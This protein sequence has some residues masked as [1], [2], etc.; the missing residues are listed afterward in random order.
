MKVL[1]YSFLVLSLSTVLLTSFAF[2]YD[3]YYVREQ[4]QKIQQKY[5]HLLGKTQQILE[6]QEATIGQ[7]QYLEG[8]THRLMAWAFQKRKLK[9]NQL[10][11]Q[12]KSDSPNLIPYHTRTKDVPG[13]QLEIAQSSLSSILQRLQKI[14]KLLATKGRAAD[15]IPIL[16]PTQGYVTSEFGYRKSP[17]TGKRK[18]HKGIDIR[19]T[20]GTKVIATAKGTVIFAGKRGGYG[21]MVVVKHPYDMQTRYA[22]LSKISVKKGQKLKVR[23][24]VG[25]VGHSGQSTG[26]HLHYET[27]Y[28]GQFIDPRLFITGDQLKFPVAKNPGVQHSPK[29]AFNPISN[30]F[31]EKSLSKLLV[32]VKTI[33]LFSFITMM[34]IFSIQILLTYI[35]ITVRR[36]ISKLFLQENPKEL[37]HPEDLHPVEFWTSHPRKN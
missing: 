35:R 7:L 16:S 33:V 21:N 9:L 28:K 8:R 4:S 19:A 1:K 14:N 26:D 13:S 3:W 34:L 18:L 29:I 27:V 36:I 5:D 30:K 17:V 11:A 20:E 24:Q 23:S 37:Y 12:P 6:T 10:P 32:R 22:H 25:L 2:I 31:T 15:A